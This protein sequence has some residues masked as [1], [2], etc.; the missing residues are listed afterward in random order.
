MKRR[1]LLGALLSVPLLA[2]CSMLPVIPRRPE[3]TRADAMGW[4][5]HL[6][7]GRF[8]LRLPRAE[9]GQHIGTALRRIAADELGVALGAISLAL[10]DSRSMSPVRATVGSDSVKDFALPLAQACAALREALAGRPP[11]EWPASALRSLNGA[12]RQQSDALGF[13]REI[14]SGA[15]LFAA[16]VRLPGLLYGRVLRAPVSPELASRPAGFNAAAARAL[17][18]FVA[19]V[20]HPGLTR[21]NSQGLGLLARTPGAL[22]RIEAALALQWQVEDGNAADIERLLQLPAQGRLRHQLRADEVAETGAWDVDLVFETPL[23]AHNGIEPRCAVADYRAADQSLRLWTGT[24]DLFYVRD[25]LVR[26]L[27]LDEAKVQVHACRAG[28]AFGARTLV[29]VEPEAALLS[30]AAGAPVKVQWTRAQELQQGFHR[31]PSRHQLRARL[32][33]GRVSDWWHRLISSHILF[34]PAAMPR[35]MQGL[36][37]FAGDG[38]VSRGALPPYALPRQRIE[39]DAR[40]LPVHTGPWRGL[41]AGPNCWVIESAIDECAHLAGIDPLAFRLAHL[42]NARLRRVLQRVAQ[43]A[44]WPRPALSDAQILRGRG[45]ACGIYKGSAYAA[46]IAEVEVERA[47]GAA[48]VSAM[49]CAHDCGRIIQPDGVRAQIEGNLVW[50]LGMVLIEALPVDKQAGIAASGFAEAPIPRI[51]DLPVLHIELIDTGEPSGGAGETA[52]VA[53]AGAIAN[54]LRAAT[55]RRFTRLPVRADD[56]RAAAGTLAR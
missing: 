6:G 3:P 46:V 54:A 37:D 48:R 36:A 1:E 38:G 11:R 22:D 14:V 27:A 25:T 8:E 47:S 4:I 28:G 56:L 51:H 7:A 43:A 16:D 31:P 24:Q 44:D 12:P 40:R 35:W 30:R 45:L 41:G 26:R 55:G 52:M 5:S 18:G 50:C 53:G 2:G 17:P 20:E 13:G 29:L 23:A 21:A 9:I 19:L 39:F 34:T 10:P 32:Q 15:P 42:D 33:H 49:H